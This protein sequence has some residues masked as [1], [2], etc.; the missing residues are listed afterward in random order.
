[1]QMNDQVKNYCHLPN[2]TLN[3]IE[4]SLCYILENYQTKDGVRLPEVLQPFMLGFP[5]LHGGFEGLSKG[6]LVT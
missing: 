2:Y 6:T 4:R 5:P 1:M 3:A